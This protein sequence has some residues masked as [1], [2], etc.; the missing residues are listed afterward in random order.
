MEVYSV[1]QQSETAAK[2]AQFIGAQERERARIARE[3]HDAVGQHLAIISNEI[4]L[5]QSKGAKT[6]VREMLSRIEGLIG[7]VAHYLD[8][9]SHRLHPAVLDFSGLVPAL[10]MFCAE[11]QRREGVQ[12]SVQVTDPPKFRNKEAALALYRIV[13]EA[14][15]NIKKHSRSKTALVEMTR[16]GDSL[17]LSIQDDGIGISAKAK[18]GKRSRRG[19]GLIGIRERV[20][21]MG[22]A[23]KIKTYSGQGTQLLV[24]VPIEVVTRETDLDTAA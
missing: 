2:I 9:L 7:E 8:D 18:P 11:F 13:Q 22:G 12:V 1:N 23:F 21:L 5:I 20:R 16:S 6:D 24:E 19:L 4:R 10:K 15:Q 3:L 14:L 17:L